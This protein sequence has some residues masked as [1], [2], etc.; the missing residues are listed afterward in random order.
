MNGPS[1]P[2][3]APRWACS[4]AGWRWKPFAVEAFPEPLR[5]VLAFTLVVTGM[6]ISA[7]AAL[8][9]ISVESSMRHG[10]PL[11]LPLIVPFL[12][13]AGAVTAAVVA[14]LILQN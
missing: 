14:F 7:G 9:W 2:G 11:P 3:S 13:L 5:K 12:G 10:K 8:R 1:S 6:L 4:Q